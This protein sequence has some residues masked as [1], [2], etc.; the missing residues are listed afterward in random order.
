MVSKRVT[1]GIAI[2][3]V[4]VW[5]LSMVADMIP[6]LHYDPPVAIYPALMIVLG[7]IFGLRIVKGDID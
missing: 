7:G 3:V 1:T 6:A 2:V 5:A 4:T